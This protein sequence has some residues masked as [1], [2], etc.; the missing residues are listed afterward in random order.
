[1]A[2]V[3]GWKIHALS[4]LIH[5]MALEMRIALQAGQK[6]NLKYR[7]ILTSY[8]PRNGSCILDIVC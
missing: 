2:F 8:D 4:W 5:C 7:Y 1:M 6:W 3:F